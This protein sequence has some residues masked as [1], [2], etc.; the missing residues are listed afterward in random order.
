MTSTSRSKPVE[1]AALNVTRSEVAGEIRTIL[2]W[3]GSHQLEFFYCAEILLQVGHEIVGRAVR[4]G[5]QAE[6]GIRVGDRVGVGAQS[7]ACLRPDCEECSNGLENHCRNA[8]VNTYNDF[9]PDGSSKSMGGYAQYC[10][11]PSHFV[12][13]IP[14]GLSS[15]EAAP[16][17]CGGVTTYT[18]LVEN[19]AGP[20][21]KVGIVGV[22]GLGHFAILWSKVRRTLKLCSGSML[23]KPLGSGLH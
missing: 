14:R 12:I 19:G 16:M 3:Y 23:I 7:S 4:V 9:Y 20:G 5:T 21:M 8:S 10:R 18:P 17:L 2:S 1:C 6:G 15:I 11:V 22:G 13:K